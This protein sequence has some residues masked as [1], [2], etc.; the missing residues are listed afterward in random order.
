MN[1]GTALSSIY[2]PTDFGAAFLAKVEQKQKRKQ[3]APRQNTKQH[4]QPP[5]LFD[6]EN[7]EI[8]TKS[9]D[10]MTPDKKRR[11]FCIENQWDEKRRAEFMAKERRQRER[12]FLE[13]ATLHAEGQPERAVDNRLVSTRKSPTQDKTLNNRGPVARFYHREWSGEYRVSIESFTRQGD[14]PA[15]QAGERYTEKL[16]ERAARSIID[17]GA[18]MAVKKGGFVTFGTA[19]FDAE[20][21]EKLQKVIAHDGGIADAGECSNGVIA[22][23]PFCRVLWEPETTIG[24]EMS[25]LFDGLQKMR[26]RGW[27]WEPTEKEKEETLPLWEKTF[28][29]PEYEQAPAP[30]GVCG[31]FR[32]PRPLNYIWVAE[33]PD[34]METVINGVGE[35]V[36]AKTGE[37]PHVHFLIDWQVDPVH[38]LGWAERIENI[39]GNGYVK[40]ERIKCQK[41]AAT[42]ILK[43]LGYMTKGAASYDENTGEILNTQGRIRGNRYNISRAA[44]APKWECIAE[45]DAELMSQFVATVGQQIQTKQAQMK[46]ALNHARKREKEAAAKLARWRNYQNAPAKKIADSIARYESQLARAKQA[47]ESLQK[48][49]MNNAYANKY[50]V[51][52]RT[53]KQLD[54]FIEQAITHNGWGANLLKHAGAAAIDEAKRISNWAK[55]KGRAIYE[56]IRREKNAIECWWQAVMSAPEPPEPDNLLIV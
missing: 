45:Y 18:Y 22:D 3:E 13:V 41:A 40:M 53:K 44:R 14:A 8:E 9:F 24:R 29:P 23:G 43:A 49:R 35:T 55:D 46:E 16:T 42:Y 12:S 7:M 34:K 17:S 15:A 48:A 4:W 36:R 47:G 38:F 5:P 39:W 33:N 2:R 21:R 19:T 54:K 51:T 1:P 27:H 25:R 52:F 56:T 32:K 26:Q 30:A 37:N 28:M 11:F 31:P 50:R 20:T 10:Q 6:P